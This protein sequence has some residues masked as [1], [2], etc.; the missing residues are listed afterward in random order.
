MTSLIQILVIVF[1]TLG[2]F[3][4]V[5][6]VAGYIRLPDV[7]CRLHTTGKVTVFGVVLLLVATAMWSP[8]T[9]GHALVLVF[10]LLATGPS[11]AHAMGSAA[12]RIGLPRKNA[13][14][15][16]LGKGETMVEGE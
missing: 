3:F 11:T 14:R 13:V 10:F 2:T 12:F 4:S 1:V 7:F 9:W 8:V 5:V 6:A 16:D 15:D